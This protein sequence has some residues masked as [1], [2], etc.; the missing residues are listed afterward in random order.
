MVCFCKI[1]LQVAVVGQSSAHPKYP[2][3]LYWFFIHEHGLESQR[4]VLAIYLKLRRDHV[5]DALQQQITG[6]TD[7]RLCTDNLWIKLHG[8]DYHDIQGTFGNH[9]YGEMDRI[10]SN[11]T[12]QY[13]VSNEYLHLTILFYSAFVRSAFCYCIS[14]KLSTYL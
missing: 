9:T 3:S 5:L 11:V 8:S 4:L 6:S 14:T 13:L 2:T 7:F 12:P 10:I 1:T